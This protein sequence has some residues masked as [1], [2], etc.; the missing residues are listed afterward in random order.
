MRKRRFWAMLELRLW[1]NLWSCATKLLNCSNVITWFQSLVNTRAE[2]AVN[3]LMDHI[4]PCLPRNTILTSRMCL[5]VWI[6]SQEGGCVHRDRNMARKDDT[7]ESPWSTLGGFYESSGA[8]VT[9]CCGLM[10]ITKLSVYPHSC[11]LTWHQQAPWWTS[12]LE[13]IL[14]MHSAVLILCV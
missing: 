10:S 4:R 14:V 8:S 7:R 5:P 1:C 11:Y 6:A 3:G 13:Y 2:N 12:K 9:Q